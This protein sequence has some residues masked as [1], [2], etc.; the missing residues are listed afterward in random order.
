[1]AVGHVPH[2]YDVPV[3]ALATFSLTEPESATAPDS[4]V[5]QDM[6]KFGAV[7]MENRAVFRLHCIYSN[8]T[9]ENQRKMECDWDSTCTINAP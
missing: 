6:S 1:M 9:L 7:L 2:I 5:A 3:T 4:P 8:M